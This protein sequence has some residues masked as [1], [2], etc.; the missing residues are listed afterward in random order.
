[1]GVI[2]VEAPSLSLVV[3]QSIRHITL[4]PS[5]DDLL[6]LAG[7]IESGRLTPVI[8]ESYELSRTADALASFGAGHVRGK[9]V[10]T[11]P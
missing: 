3:P 7:L 10:L 6:T 2:L 4:K 9:I 5:R 11:V 1:M 8:G